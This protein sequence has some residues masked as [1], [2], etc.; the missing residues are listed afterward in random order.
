MDADASLAPRCLGC[1]GCLLA[2]QTEPTKHAKTSIVYR[3]AHGAALGAPLW[4]T[5]IH[6]QYIVWN[7]S[8]A[9]HHL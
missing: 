3:Y 9:L 7:Y 5:H 8:A 1:L 6:S 4:L 2:E